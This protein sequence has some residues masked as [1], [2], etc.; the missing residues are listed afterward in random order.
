MKLPSEKELKILVIKYHTGHYALPGGFVR[1]NEDLSDAVKRGLRDRTSL[2]NIF[3]EQFHTFGSLKRYDSETV[4]EIMKK[5]FSWPFKPFVI[6]WTE[7]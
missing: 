4:R 2:S 5:S 3:L 6:T 1:R 7:N